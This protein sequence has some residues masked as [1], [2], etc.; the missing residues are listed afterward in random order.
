[1]AG[2]VVTDTSAPQPPVLVRILQRWIFSF[3]KNWFLGISLLLGLYVGLPFLAPVFMV[4][5]LQFPARIIYGIY[6]FLCHQL[7]QRSY[8]LFGQ[9]FTYS[10]LEIQAAWQPTFSFSILRQFIGNPQ[11]GWK[12]AWS[13]R[14]VSMYTSIL[15]F[16]WVWYALRKRIGRL[17]WQGFLVFLLPLAVDGLAHTVSD[18]AGIGQGFRDTNTWLAL[19]TNNSLP[20]AFYAGDAW[21]SFN[22]IVR[23]VS[24]AFFGAG[25]VWFTYPYL[26]EYFEDLRL[27]I[28]EK[29][30][31]AGVSLK[32]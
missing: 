14:M 4:A 29:F 19:L 31:R 11:M 6:S 1:M 28:Q 5:G 22:S 18:F 7:P 32:S 15:F 23:L 30:A 2:L 12:V 9:K 25:V 10:L 21:G 3:A 24:G 27:K 17:S 20:P 16:S 26:N 8:F 13:D